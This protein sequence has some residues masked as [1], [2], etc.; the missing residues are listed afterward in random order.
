[1]METNP[2]SVSRTVIHALVHASQSSV[3]ASSHFGRQMHTVGE[4]RCIYELAMGY[5]STDMRYG[6]DRIWDKI[7]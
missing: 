5:L 7:S 4:L 3:I 1:M 2:T 6:V